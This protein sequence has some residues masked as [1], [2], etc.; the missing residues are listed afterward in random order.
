MYHQSLRSDSAI[1]LDALSE[2]RD[3]FEVSLFLAKNYTNENLP[4]SYEKLELE[5]FLNERI[6]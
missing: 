3:A 1:R 5:E 2:I 6:F 4:Y